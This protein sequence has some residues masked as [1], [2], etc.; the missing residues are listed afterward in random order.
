MGLGMK[1]LLFG[2]AAASSLAL[3]GVAS[4]ASVDFT[5]LIA[6]GPSATGTV[7]SLTD[8]DGENL[9][10]GAGN[11]QAGII[12]AGDM[13]YGVFD[14][15]RI[16]N[17]SHVSPGAGIG[18]GTVYSEL[19][20]I[21]LIQVL[22]KT[23]AGGG[24]FN[25]TFGANTAQMELQFGLSGLTTGTMVRLFDDLNPNFT[26]GGSIASSIASAK[27][28]TVLLDAGFT[29]V[30]GIADPGQGWIVLN[31]SDD[32]GSLANRSTS[33]TLGTS[34]F[35]I[36][37]T[38]TVGFIGGLNLLQQTTPLTTAFGGSA[39]FVGSSTIK[40]TLGSNIVWGANSQTNID[41]VA[42]VPVSTAAWMGFPL[43]FVMGGCALLRRRNVQ[44]I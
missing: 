33:V 44:L 5:G 30:G 32:F 8:A 36:D 26:L 31:G 12:E 23:S 34:N 35:A 13:I 20:G 10:K 25:F 3:S 2:V 29:G 42:A 41:F 21:S 19:T 9:L 7:N 22:S 18:L 43:L 39:A 1:E 14:Y 6:Y 38:S 4:A 37:V 27:D 11:T 15:N 28:G 16:T 17:A 40:G 24:L